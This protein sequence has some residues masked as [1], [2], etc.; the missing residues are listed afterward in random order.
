M[1]LHEKLHF[2]V[3]LRN[4]HY[5]LEIRKLHDQVSFHKLLVVIF[6]KNLGNLKHQ[7]DKLN[8]F[9]IKRDIFYNS[10]IK[11]QL[12]HGNTI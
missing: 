10:V 8:V 5:F 4:S 3:Q 9:T 12:M 6:D 2:R 7:V 1:V 11:P